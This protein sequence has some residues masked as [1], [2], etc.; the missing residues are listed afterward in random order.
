MSVDGGVG[1]GDGC[2][3][4]AA[5]SGGPRPE[6][7][8]GSYVCVVGGGG[9]WVGERSTGHERARKRKTHPKQ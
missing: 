1:G 5:E 8:V 6:A 7:R 4:R 2:S 3:S 9:G